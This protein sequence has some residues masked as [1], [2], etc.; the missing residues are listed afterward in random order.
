M[1]SRLDALFDVG[2]AVIAS[3]KKKSKIKERNRS[4]MFLNMVERHNITDQV[5]GRYQILVNDPLKQY[6][7]DF[8]KAYKVRDR[9]QGDS[10]SKLYALVFDKSLPVRI[11]TINQLKQYS[12]PQLICPIEAEITVVSSTNESHFVTILP[13]PEGISLGSLIDPKR[14]IAEEYIT[15]QIIKPINNIINKLSQKN[16]T[17]GRINPNNIYIDSS[18][19][20]T[21]GECVSDLCGYSQPMLYEPIE[22]CTTDKL[23]KGEG[24]NSS[25]YYALGMLI[26]HLLIRKQ[27]GGKVSDKVIMHSKLENGTY[28]SF[29][30]DIDLP[31]L[32]MDL[33][34]GLLNDKKSARWTSKQIEIA[35]GGKRFNLIRSNVHIEASRSIVFN[36]KAFLNRRAIAYAFS[37]NWDACKRFLMEN[38]LI[39]WIGGSMSLAEDA[40]QIKSAIYI[41]RGMK[42]IFEHDGNDELVARTISI[43][44]PDGPIRLKNFCAN[45][46]AIGDV[47]AVSYLE[48]NQEMILPISYILTRKLTENRLEDQTRHVGYNM[49]W[50]MEKCS[51][52]INKTAYGFG[53]ERCLYELN[54]FLPCQSEYVLKDY[55]LTLDE[56][57]IALDKLAK[58]KGDL[59][60]DRHIAAFIA[61][62]IDLPN[63]VYIKQL[64]KFPEFSKHHRLQMLALL[65]LA[66][67]NSSIKQLRGLTMAVAEYL[68]PVLDQ[69][70][71]SSIRDELETNIGMLGS[72]GSLVALFKLVSDPNFV[73]RDISGFIGA[74]KDY[75]DLSVQIQKLDNKNTLANVG[76]RYGLQLSVI[77][78]Y[79]LSFLL[80]AIFIA[81]GI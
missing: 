56:L 14:P 64:S 42:K 25:D 7:S 31:P 27:P 10:G 20:I 66:Q 60:I 57:L 26:F 63:E 9:K 52:Y 51:L 74:V 11:A 78:A 46:D 50:A 61:S 35:L 59:P 16:I 1:R 32:F 65:T 38:I 36:G 23:G 3:G 48:E 41:T 13:E 69:F 70:H 62:R 77:A 54:P 30:G 49:V 71:S 58:A 79:I 43:I 34:R 22:R 81:S 55:V 72:E 75:R 28:N 5:A 21:L 29:V 47:L 80:I 39:K 17:H 40:E 4:P 19:R 18:N 44:D 8:A 33:I 45:V 53:I 2:K 15:S 68:E 37:Q 24:D 12:V 67:K 73:I 76:Y 6:D